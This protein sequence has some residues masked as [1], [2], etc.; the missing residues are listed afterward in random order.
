M[1]QV[2][3]NSNH[4]QHIDRETSQQHSEGV[5][6]HYGD[7]GAATKPSIISRRWAHA[8]TCDLQLLLLYVRQL[9]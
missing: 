1:L 3:L 8:I 7:Q 2:S 5:G 4:Q 6:L 9:C